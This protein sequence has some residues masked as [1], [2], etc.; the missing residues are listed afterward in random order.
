V[1]NRAHRMIG[2]RHEILRPEEVSPG[3]VQRLFAL[4][5]SCYEAV[6]W[7]SFM[8]D[9][10]G[11]TWVI[12]LRDSAGEARGFSTQQVETVEW[13][14]EEI[15][16][17]FSG[18]TIVEPACWGSAELVKGWCTVAARVLA[19]E[20]RR[21]LFWFLISKGFRTYLYL[22]LFFR[23]FEPR[24]DSAGDETLT[25][26]LDS[27]AR[28]R[29]GEDWKPESGLVK[30]AE[31]KGHLTP[32]LAE[33]PAGREN[34]PHVQFFRSRNPGYAAGDELACLAEVTLENTHGLGRRWLGQAVQK[35]GGG[36]R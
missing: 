13:Q 31:S 16:V 17:L 9:L 26:L 34:D 32:G 22:P 33:V 18:D 21:R 24:V 25:P 15:R 8:D 5:T 3:L 29:F 12:I 6:S 10:S 2:L 4:M 36:A 11:K 20:P 27:L 7:A 14:G 19:E 23:A 35:E 30:F 28:R 1:A